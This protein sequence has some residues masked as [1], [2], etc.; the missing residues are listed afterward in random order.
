VKI[1]KTKF[2]G[3]LEIKFDI[4]SDKRGNFI[5]IFNKSNS[6]FFKNDCYE[7]YIN[8]SKK[9]VVRGLHGQLG[10]HSQDK[11][12]Y[13]I[14]GQIVDLAL[15]LRKNSKTYGKLYKKKISAKDSTA[16]FIP[17]GFV[18]GIVA[19]E[20]ETI[21]VNYCSTPY[22]QSNEFGIRLDSLPVKF[23]NLKLI[24]SEKDKMLPTYNEFIKKNI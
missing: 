6:K 7:S 1:K 21:V 3:L 14:K 5:K 12:I 13:C 24:F 11:L 9:G 15:D 16:I 4:F 8:T 23:K 19:L 20:K 10:K 17:K 2:I 22:N 18:H